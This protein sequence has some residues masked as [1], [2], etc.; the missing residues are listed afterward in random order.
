MMHSIPHNETQEIQANPAVRRIQ[1]RLLAIMD[2]IVD[3]CKRHDIPYWLESGTLLGAVR[4][5]G[6]IPWDD[7]VDLGILSEDYQRFLE[8][9]KQSLASFPKETEFQSR[10]TNRSYYHGSPRFADTASVGKKTRTFMGVRY[11][12]RESPFVDIFPFQRYPYPNK[13]M[14]K[15]SKIANVLLK[16]VRIL[17]GR[18]YY[19]CYESIVRQIASPTGGY[20]GYATLRRITAA[21][22]QS[23]FPLNEIEFEGRMY[24]A[25]GDPH[26]YLR[27]WY[28][29]HYMQIPPESARWSHFRWESP[30]PD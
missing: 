22:Y 17:S 9:V 20:L 7:D 19:Y 24:S 3:L 18:W 2:A 16:P 10:E 12:C 30:N 25:P 26:E 5:K 8:A 1:L 6:F 28:G 23:V 27:N 21:P 4:H 11:E 13:V 14:L 15:K 29:D